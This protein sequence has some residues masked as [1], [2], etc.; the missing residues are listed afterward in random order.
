MMV[1]RL[2]GLCALVCALVLNLTNLDVM[3]ASAPTGLKKVAIAYSSISP[4]QAPAWAA[5]ETGIFRNYGLDVQLIFVESGSRTVQ[6]LVSGDV[7]AAEVAG[8]G[9]IQSNL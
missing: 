9:V 3:A 6:T 5:Y 8:A 4:N 2:A 1:R 7:V